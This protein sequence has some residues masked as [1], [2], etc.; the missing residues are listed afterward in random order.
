MHKDEMSVEKDRSRRRKLRRYL[1]GA[2]AVLSGCWLV[3]YTV[4]R[5]FGLLL[6]T[7][8]WNIFSSE[9]ASIGIIGGADGPTAIFVTGK[10]GAIPGWDVILVLLIF[11]G[12]I[13]A[14]LCLRSDRKK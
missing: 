6:N 3:C 11:I 8:S 7:L 14:W 10:P 1:A 12:S 13:I 9:A 2:A 5:R 4:L